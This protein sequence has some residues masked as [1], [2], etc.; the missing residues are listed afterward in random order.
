MDVEE[1]FTIISD[2]DVAKKASKKAESDFVTQL[3]LVG[4]SVLPETRKRWWP[5]NVR[6]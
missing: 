4:F 2:P 6:D 5:L 1:N 3:N